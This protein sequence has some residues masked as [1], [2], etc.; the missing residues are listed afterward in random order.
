MED[1]VAREEQR[2][3][4]RQG[5]GNCWN[6]GILLQDKTDF[7]KCLAGQNDKCSL[8]ANLCLQV[9]KSPHPDRKAAEYRAEG[10]EEAGSLESE[11]MV[12]MVLGLGPE[13][14]EAAQYFLEL[15]D[16][17]A[18]DLEVFTRVRE[19]AARGQ[20]QLETVVRTNCAMF[21]GQVLDLLI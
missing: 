6:L 7:V 8:E 17:S 9:H 12:G 10:E 19:M 21:K 14:W 5:V 4:G 13:D 3:A 18:P 16:F 15:E 11:D 1:S 2:P 20:G